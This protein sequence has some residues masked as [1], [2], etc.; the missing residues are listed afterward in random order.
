MSLIK[1]GITRGGK[2]FEFLL[3]KEVQKFANIYINMED[4]LD[5]QVWPDDGKYQP[6]NLFVSNTDGHFAIEKMLSKIEMEQA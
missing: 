4:R 6:R 3:L 5:S 2:D 1:L